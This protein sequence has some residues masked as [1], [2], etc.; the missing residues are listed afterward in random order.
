MIHAIESK[1]Y[2]LNS[3]VEQ[4]ASMILFHSVRFCEVILKWL[5]EVKDIYSKS[6]VPTIASQWLGRKNYKICWKPVTKLRFGK[7]E[8]LWKSLQLWSNRFDPDLELLEASFQFPIDL[9]GKRK[10]SYGTTSCIYPK[11][12]LN[13]SQH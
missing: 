8:S 4:T 5:L 9:Y 7:S 1:V 6:L 3:I 12:T 10:Q 2:V 11:H 13:I